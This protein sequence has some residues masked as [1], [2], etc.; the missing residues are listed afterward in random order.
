VALGLAAELARQELSAAQTH[1]LS[2]RR[3]I[4]AKVL[5]LEGAQLNG[6]VDHRL[7]NTSHFSFEGVDGHHLVVALDLNGVCVSSGPACSSGASAPSHVLTA[8]GLDPRL[9]VSSIRVSVGFGT[10]D[11]DVDQFLDVLPRAVERLRMAAAH[12]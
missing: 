3:R 2:L 9:A 11:A 10:T 6:H 1:A 12:I 8:M 5:S 4:E 7:P